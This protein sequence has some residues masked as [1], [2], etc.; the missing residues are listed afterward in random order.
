MLAAV[1]MCTINAQSVMKSS[2]TYSQQKRQEMSIENDTSAAHLFC[3]YPCQFSLDCGTDLGLIMFPLLCLEGKL[4]FGLI[5]C[6]P[7][8][9]FLY[10]QFF[11]WPQLVFHKQYTVCTIKTKQ[12]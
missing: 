9:L 12:N 5:L 8:L 10:H 11:L 3:C 4:I 7:L 2:S 6:L 1:L